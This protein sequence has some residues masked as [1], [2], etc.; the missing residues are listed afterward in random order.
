MASRTSASVGM[1]VTLAILSIL[2]LGLFVTS[3]VFFAKVQK[4][5]NDLRLKQ[6]DL[7]AAVR[8]D[9]R[10]E[11]WEDLKRSAGGRSGV[12][13]YLD[14]SFQDVAA[15]VSGSRREEAD[16]LIERIKTAQGPEGLPL[17][18]VIENKNA[19]IDALQK[20]VQAAE[21]I[22]AAARADQIASGDRIARLQEEHQATV[23]RLNAEIG[24]Y[25]SAIEE[26]RSGVETA[27]GSMEQRV[28]TMKVDS[29]STIAS[30]ESRVND[31]ESQLLVANDQLRRLRGERGSE[32]LRPT[33]EGAL[34]DGRVVG[35][36]AAARQVYLDLGR[37]DRIVLGMSFE[38]YSDAASV[39]PGPDGDYPPGKG[40][41]EIVRIEE[42]SSIA[43]IVRENAGTPII[44][45]DVIANAV[46]DPRKVYTFTVY[47]NFDT[48]GDGVATG[49]EGQDVRALIEQWNGKVAEDISGE[50]DFLVLGFKPVLPPQP[51]P[52]DPVE[53]IQ[54]YLLLRQAVQRYDDLFSAAQQAGI[55]VLNQNRLYTLIGLPG[56]GQR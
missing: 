18:R 47:G 4:L 46:Y 34:V 14:R 39:K 37:R 9:E 11:R 10:D 33:F 49:M 40:S 15:M 45:G 3:I 21:Q 32:Q 30:L 41:I 26:Y 7:D 50:T 24:A 5:T 19:E 54:R 29:D 13:R 6:A 23:D 35:A 22:A 2:T 43:R 52:T 38:V 42:T 28:T 8:S 20:R 25:K 56:A 1:T 16:R 55:P 31:L 27:K 48:D 17:I 36:N 12:V 44:T 51:K 53:L